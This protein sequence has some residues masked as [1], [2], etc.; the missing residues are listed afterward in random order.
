MFS[1]VNAYPVIFSFYNFTVYFISNSACNLAIDIGFVL[2]AS[3]RRGLY[4]FKRIKQFVAL[5]SRSFSISRS[6]ARVGVIVYG[7]TARMEFGLNSYTNSRNLNRAIKRLRYTRGS[8]KTGKALRIVVGGLF[9]RSR[10]KRVLILVTNGQ[11]YDNVKIPSF[12]IHQAGIEV[13]AVG[14]GTR[15][16]NSELSTIAT[17]PRHI[18]MVNFKTLNGIARSI[19]RKAC[20][21]IEHCLSIVATFLIIQCISYGELRPE[22][23]QC[24]LHCRGTG[25]AKVFGNFWKSMHRF[26]SLKFV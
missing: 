8:R 5:V 26:Q 13:F 14:V 15:V 1:Y 9:R 25:N 16:R 12:Q 21:G 19:V 23:K 7:S 2:D 6:R 3:G 17:D 20:R 11:S 10:K 18:Y 4:N 24:D 22:Q